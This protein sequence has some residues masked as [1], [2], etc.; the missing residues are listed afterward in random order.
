[1]Y[2]DTTPSPYSVYVHMCEVRG[3]EQEVEREG[4]RG[5]ERR[6]TP[7]STLD[8]PAIVVDTLLHSLVLP[9]VVDDERLTAATATV[10]HC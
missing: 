2:S 3:E 8:E 7:T 4:E 9:A 6:E 10:T 5:V 1:M